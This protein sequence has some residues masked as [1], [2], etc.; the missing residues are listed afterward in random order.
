MFVSRQMQERRS[1]IEQDEARLANVG[2]HLPK[3]GEGKDHRCVVCRKRHAHWFSMNPK[4]NPKECPFS[5]ES[6]I[7]DSRSK[8][9]DPEFKIHTNS[10]S[11]IQDSH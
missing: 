3:R 7:Q 1:N 4:A 8:I 2:V 5:R 11:G 10:R 6:L 9:Q